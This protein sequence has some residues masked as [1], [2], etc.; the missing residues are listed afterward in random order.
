MRRL[1]RFPSRRLPR[2]GWQAI[3]LIALLLALSALQQWRPELF[4]R[5]APG[6]LEPGIYRVARVVDGDTLVLANTTEHVRL[7]GADTPETVKPNWPVERCGRE[8][9]AFA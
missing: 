6:P 2:H 9:T 8:A 3:L 7:I 1:Y 5:A 4:Q